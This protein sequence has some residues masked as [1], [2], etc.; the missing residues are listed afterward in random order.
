MRWEKSEW[1]TMSYI[2]GQSL[3]REFHTGLGV[4]PEYVVHS[5]GPDVHTLLDLPLLL[6]V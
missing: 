6:L 2:G 1:Y 3:I 5:P 4:D